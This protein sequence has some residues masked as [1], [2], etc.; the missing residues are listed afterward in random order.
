MREML[1]IGSGAF[2]LPGAVIDF[3]RPSE[4]HRSGGAL[5]LYPESFESAVAV[6]DMSCKIP[7]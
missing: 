2:E 7:A 3:S 6:E 4:P 5:I 1:E